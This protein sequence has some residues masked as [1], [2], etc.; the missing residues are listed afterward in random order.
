MSDY[1]NA[2]LGD[3]ADIDWGNTSITKQSYQTR[4]Y[5]AYSASGKDGFLANWEHDADG[6]VISA[7]GSVGN[8]SFAQGRWTAIK[9]TII[10]FGKQEICDTRFLYHLLSA[11]D[12]WNI[13][14]SS[15]KF[16]SLGNVRNEEVTLPPLPEQK[17]IAEILSGIDIRK[18]SLTRQREKLQVAYKALSGELL[19]SLPRK[20]PLSDICDLQV[21]F[22]FRS[23]DFSEA[24][25]RLLRGEN[26][27]YGAPNWERAQFLPNS[28]AEASSMYQVN[29]GDIV[30]GMDRSF[31]KSGFKV[32][33][34]SS[35]DLPCLLVQRVGRF[36]PKS[37]SANFL[38]HILQSPDYQ[39]VLLSSEKGMDIP[40]LSKGEILEPLV[41]VAD[42][43]T[44]DQVSNSLDS[45]LKSIRSVDASIAATSQLGAA[46]R[47]DL[48]SGR[49]RV[50]DAQVLEGVGA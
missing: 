10:A 26:V 23:T 40:H 27:G 35:A 12:D 32:S 4:G 18:E 1:T 6:V 42:T 14:G 39:R 28:L 13:S 50:T 43:P 22:P 16:L 47:S 7:I 44:Q 3:I 45:M 21:G 41:P 15:Q 24:G 37:I 17:K 33:K 49:K 34:I 31:T 19:G 5:P 2:L 25:V 11:K 20:V 48:L 8:I 9:N 38:W 30:I 29:A 36:A 46:L